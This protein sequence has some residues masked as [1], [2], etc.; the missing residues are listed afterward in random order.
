MLV[1]QIIV[2]NLQIG[3]TLNDS[4]NTPQIM[5]VS[6]SKF[7]VVRE[8]LVKEFKCTRAALIRMIASLIASPLVEDPWEANKV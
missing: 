8:K 1:L 6:I 2:S 5:S 7:R 3:L 4:P